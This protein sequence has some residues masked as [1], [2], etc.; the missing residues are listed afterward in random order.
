MYIASSDCAYICIL[1]SDTE[2]NSDDQSNYKICLCTYDTPICDYGEKFHRY[3]YTEYTRPLLK[4]DLNLEIVDPFNL[5]PNLKLT[6]DTQVHLQ[7]LKCSNHNCQYYAKERTEPKG[8]NIHVLILEYMVPKYKELTTDFLDELYEIL[9][10]L[11]RETHIH[12]YK[13]LGSLLKQGLEALCRECA[14]LGNLHKK[15]KDLQ[16]IIFEHISFQPS[17]LLKTAVALKEFF[18]PILQNY[19]IEEAPK[20][21]IITAK[22]NESAALNVVS[23]LHLATSKL[24]RIWCSRSVQAL[25]TLPRIS[26]NHALR[27]IGVEISIRA[28]KNTKFESEIP[29]G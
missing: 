25:S 17:S 7:K 27:K 13:N 6:K 18:K 26:L 21:H 16:S 29:D 9:W 24:L 11:M 8:T 20:N 2:T 4:D 5:A 15:Y 19:T 10:N 1:P 14:A 3:G 22:P 23:F 28:L 12:G